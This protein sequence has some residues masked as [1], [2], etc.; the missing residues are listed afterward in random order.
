MN[1]ILHGT[2]SF[3]LAY[4]DDVLVFS[5]TAAEHL[6]HVEIILKRLQDAG[7]TLKKSKCCFFCKQLQ[8]L[9]HVISQDG[10][11]PDPQKTEASA[12]CLHPRMLKLSLLFRSDWIL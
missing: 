7:L 5:R 2:G 1:M 6:E 11:K 4:L 9:G 8:Y 12:K 10:L 3:A